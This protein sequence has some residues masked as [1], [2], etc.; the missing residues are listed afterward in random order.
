MKSAA[1]FFVS[2]LLSSASAARADDKPTEKVPKPKKANRL[3][4]ESS[5]YL[6]QHAHN[7]VDWHPWGEEALAKA[8]K[9]GKMIFLSVGYSSC[10]WCHVMEK[11]SFADE[12]VAKMLNENFICIKVDREERP[13]VDQIYMT[14]LNVMGGSGGWPLSMFLAPDAKPIVGGTYWPREDK[15]EEGQKVKGFKSVLKTLLEVWTKEK[16]KVIEQSESLAKATAQELIGVTRVTPLFEMKRELVDDACEAL[17]GTHD[18]LHGGFSGLERAFRGPKFPMPPRLLL[19]QEEAARG[20]KPVAKALDLTLERI[21]LGGIYDHLG[22]GF[23][24]Y[25]TER[26]WTIPHFEK[27]LY[28]NAQLVEVY[29][30]A[31][32]RTKNPLFERVVRETLVFVGRE[33]TSKEGLFYSALDADTEG[34]EGRF[35]VWTEKEAQA[36]LPEKAERDRFMQAYAAKGINFEGKYHIFRLAKPLPEQAAEMKTTEAELRQKLAPAIKKLFEAR[37]KRARPFLDTKAIAGWN[38]QMI[39]GYAVAGQ[40][41]EDKAYL[42]TATQAAEALLANLR[43]KDGR[44][45]RTWAAA[46]GQKAEARGNAYAE[47]YAFVVH[48]LLCLHDATGAKRWLDEAKALTDALLKHHEDEKIGGFFYTS[49][50]HEKLFARAKDQYDGVQPCGNSQAAR[51]LV[52]LWKKTKDEK[53]KKAAEKTIR[54]MSVAYKTNPPGMCTLGSAIAMFLE[55]ERK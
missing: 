46:P 27:M 4:K 47:D 3:V 14:A 34:E 36:A 37:A 8:K 42:D 40:M 53:Y 45:A 55:S 10:H 49:H 28:D 52:R 50:D 30:Q 16:D 2:L 6:L 11:E 25:S 18:A 41:F 9:E 19:L 35:Y 13:D 7:P 24:R 48:G 15:E 33:M 21:A 51:N 17:L 32:K 54:S 12:G 5:P 31:W 20:S 44:L 29:S 1:C 38:G 22:G 39:A 43:T 23:H 26:T